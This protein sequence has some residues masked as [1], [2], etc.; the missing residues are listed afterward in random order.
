MPKKYH[1]ALLCGGRSAEHHVSLVSANSI[2]EKLEEQ[3]HKVSII[4]ISDQG[5]W[6]KT[7]DLRSIRQKSNQ[8]IYSEAERSWSVH[9]E[10]IASIYQSNENYDVIFPVLHGTYGEDGT[11]Q[12]LLEIIQI[13]YV[14]SGVLG[15][16][17]GMDKVIQKELLKNHNIPLVPY[18]FF[19]YGE[20]LENIVYWIDFIEK[21]LSYPIF[22]KPANAG[23]SIGISKV[24]S[25]AELQKAI[26]YAS[27]YDEKILVE[28]GI[29]NIREIECGIFGNEKPEASI[30]GEIQSSNEFYDYD[31]KY[32]DGKSNMIIPANIKEKTQEKIQKFAKKAF[33]ILEC[34]GMARVDFFLTKQGQIFF[35]EINTIPGF[36]KFS[37]YPTLWKHSGVNY[38]ELLEKLIERAIEK[39]TKQQ[40][41][42]LLYTPSKAWYE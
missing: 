27:Q 10:I 33:K 17:L 21:N 15:S 31:A 42:K 13:P 6:E 29:A 5:K 28:Q 35:N 1:I 26:E 40:G 12:G 19:R 22:I 38:G 18:C 23:S 16:A 2:A 3:G 11:V 25:Q 9:Q 34:S 37:M 39:H 8:L 30:C 36:T 20:F 32:V 14:G 24:K 4:K 41:R 7:Q